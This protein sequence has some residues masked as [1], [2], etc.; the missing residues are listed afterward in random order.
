MFDDL[1]QQSVFSYVVC[2]YSLRRRYSIIIRF[3]LSPSVHTLVL[4]TW[5][6]WPLTIANVYAL[7]SGVTCPG[8]P[9]PHA[10]AL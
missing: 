7:V 6:T 3:C 1:A 10:H 5:A 9:S 8:P 2:V 4:W